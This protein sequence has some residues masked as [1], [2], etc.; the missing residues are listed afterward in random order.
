MLI[1]LHIIETMYYLWRIN[2][3]QTI[4]QL[5]TGAIQ[6]IKNK[7][8]IYTVLA[9]EFEKSEQTI[10]RWVDDNDEMLTTV[11]ALSILKSETGLNKKDLLTEN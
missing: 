6:A 7:P 10:R 3:K 11:R 8:R 1:Y 2:L 4:M 5:T 9:L